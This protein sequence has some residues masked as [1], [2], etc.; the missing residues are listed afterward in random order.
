[1]VG[2]FNHS[3]NEVIKLHLTMTNAL[4]STADRESSIWTAFG[5]VLLKNTVTTAELVHLQR[6]LIMKRNLECPHTHI[7]LFFIASPPIRTQG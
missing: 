1:M 2:M 5:F 3:V 7:L 6:N 4:L